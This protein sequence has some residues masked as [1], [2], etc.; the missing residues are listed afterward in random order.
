MTPGISHSLLALPV[1]SMVA[2]SNAI[3]STLISGVVPVVM[4][5]AIFAGVI[6]VIGTLAFERVVLAAVSR[7]AAPSQASAFVAAAAVRAR[8]LSL[9]VTGVTV[10]F[11]L[12][13][14]ILQ[15]REF[16]ADSGWVATAQALLARTQWG[17]G[18]M[19]QMAAV[20]LFIAARSADRVAPMRRGP[21]AGSP[22]VGGGVVLAVVG[23]AIAPAMTGHAIAS[24]D[25]AVIAVVVDTL[26][27]VAAGAWLGTLAVIVLVGVPT[28]A[29]DAAHWV[30]RVAHMVRAL[31]PMA[32]VSAAVMLLTGI[33]AS[34]M[35]LDDISSLWMTPY[36]RL[37]AVK[38]GLFV[39]IALTGA[40]NWRRVTPR[41]TDASGVRT[42]AR[43]AVVEVAFA[44]LLLAVTAVLVAT[45]MPAEG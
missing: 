25:H 31:S 44:T 26:H 38:V 16:S 2:D 13:R 17:R 11:V 29:A 42:L 12:L 4:R 36:G 24:P 27:V 7:H 15:V 23:M 32:L 40:Y 9:V 18:S 19:I 1:A 35:H 41:L 39:L 45:A 3:A 21:H 33:I 5:L 10:P 22:V 30:D 28:A 37:L 8:R 14:F 43:S 6:L 34:W 20:L